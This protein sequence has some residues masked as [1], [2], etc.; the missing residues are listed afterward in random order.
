M[1]ISSV[2]GIVLFVDVVRLNNVI[3]VIY[4]WTVVV[5]LSPV[6][7]PSTLLLHPLLLSRCPGGL[8]FLSLLLYGYCFLF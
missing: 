6:V 7:V 4:S 5:V 2:S 1:F 3:N 8:Q